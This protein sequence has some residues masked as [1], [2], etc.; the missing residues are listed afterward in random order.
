MSVQDDELLRLENDIRDQ[1][2]G[3]DLAPIY[4]WVPDNDLVVK[5]VD[6]FLKNIE[7]G[8]MDVAIRRDPALYK[9]FGLEDSNQD[10]QTFL[11]GDLTSAQ[12]VARQKIDPNTLNEISNE[13]KSYQGLHAIAFHRVANHLYESA[14]NKK[15]SKDRKGAA[16]DLLLARRISQGVR[17]L[18]GGIEIHPG[19][20]IGEK[21]F[22]DHGAGV[23]IGET[24]EI[25]DN[26][27]LYHN[28]T[29]G[30][31]PGKE[32]ARE[33][34]GIARR[35]P[36]IG[37]DVVISNSVNILGPVTL[38]DGVK[39]SPG[40]EVRQIGKEP[41]V[42]GKGA[43]IQD[44]VIVTRKVEE[45]ARVVGALPALPGMEPAMQGEL[46]IRDPE[47]TKDSPLPLTMLLTENITKL[48]KVLAGLLPAAGPSPAH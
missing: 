43:S 32:V 10:L 9:R 3:T 48:G 40:V 21:F 31:S 11:N 44:G 19:A 41:L 38:E 27:F 22:I 35:H 13:V 23:V 34:G 7:P 36:K 15:N 46:V 12:L 37:N 39:I 20:T 17:R 24:A 18:T 14:Q 28:V 45:G 29:L 25:G 30:A 1:F 47:S 6:H 42:I 33:G 16:E 26:V 5:V 4:S 8:W 2:A